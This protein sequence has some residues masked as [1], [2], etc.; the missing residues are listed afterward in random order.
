MSGV[1]SLA[2][3]GISITRRTEL[4]T[5]K[6]GHRA[7]TIRLFLHLGRPISEER[8]VTEGTEQGTECT[9]WAKGEGWLRI[10]Q[11]YTGAERGAAPQG[12]RQV[13]GHARTSRG[14]VTMES[15]PPN[16]V[17]IFT[18]RLCRSLELPPLSHRNSHAFPGRT[19]RR[20]PLARRSKQKQVFQ[21]REQEVQE[22]DEIKVFITPNSPLE[23]PAIIPL[24]PMNIGNLYFPSTN[25]SLS[26][27]LT[28]SSVLLLVHF[29]TKN[30]G[31]NSVPNAWQSLVEP[32]HDFVPNLVNEQIGGLSGNV[33]QKFSPRISVTF[34]SS[35]FRNPQVGSQRNGLHFS[36][37]S[38]PAGVPLP[39]APP[40]VLPE[41]IPHC[42]RASS[43]GIRLSANMMA[44]HSS[45]RI[46]SGSARTM[47]WGREQNEAS[48]IPPANRCAGTLSRKEWAGGS[49]GFTVPCGGYPIEPLVGGAGVPPMNNRILPTRTS[50]SKNKA[51]NHD[52]SCVLLSIMVPDKAEC[53]VLQLALLITHPFR[54]C[55]GLY[56]KGN[57]SEQESRVGL[58][59]DRITGNLRVSLLTLSSGNKMGPSVVPCRPKTLHQA[60][61]GQSFELRCSEQSLATLLPYI[62]LEQPAIIPLIPM[63]I[64]N[65]YFPSTNPSLSMPLTISSVLLLVHFVT[66]NGGGNSVP[67]AWQSLVEPIHDFVPNLV[68]EQIGGLSGNVKQ[69]FSPRISVTFTSSSFR[70][71]QVGSQRNGLHFSSFSSPAGV[72]LPLAPPSVLPE[73]IPHC[74]R[75]SSSGIRLSANMMA[76]HSSVRISSGSARTMPWGR[77]QNEASLIPPAN[78][79]AGTLSRK[80][81]A[82][83][84]TGFTVPCGGYP[85]EPLVG[86]AGVPPMNNRGGIAVKQPFYRKKWGSR[87]LPP[88]HI[89]V[90]EVLASAIL[91]M[92]KR[93]WDKLWGAE[94]GTPPPGGLLRTSNSKNKA[95]NHDGS[96]VLL[97]IMVPDK[98]E[99][100]VLQLALL[101]THPF[102]ACYGL[103]EKGNGS[104]QESRVGLKDDRITGNS[105]GAR[106]AN[107]PWA[108]LICG[109]DHWTESKKE[110]DF[111]MLLAN[112]LLNPLRSGRN[113][114]IRRPSTPSDSY[115][116]T[117]RHRTGRPILCEVLVDPEVRSNGTGGESRESHSLGSDTSPPP[118][119]GAA[120]TD[121]N[122][123]IPKLER[124]CAYHLVPCV[125]FLRMLGGDPGGWLCQRSRC[126]QLRKAELFGS[127]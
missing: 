104:E 4:G 108:Q 122:L 87:P 13:R 127:L 35:S 91:Y 32:I 33:K 51:T 82:G 79:C 21:F 47:P 23:Q 75:A 96:C 9:D 111:P 89:A 73:L 68:N 50:N 101:I 22:K 62:P 60:S 116:S 99:C 5:A 41:L 113:G 37:F 1:G 7:G 72:P 77:E 119:P 125:T 102:R 30:G 83:G 66:K 118:F 10:C 63:N 65:L 45:V 31:G 124:S 44:G 58:K 121:L 106:A 85:I 8:T 3:R 48:L 42:S 71:P 88:I 11:A 110:R 115:G 52:G 6:E 49:T 36:S 100:F 39:L 109:R 26:M 40:S 97:S 103:Y 57:G 76:G 59:D 70:N 93:S 107:M 12:A 105:E 120:G 18:K 123:S 53:F 20:F 43:S 95:T 15:I 64:G 98:A 24:I 78:R 27:P 29:V 56:E 55:Y 114:A 67:N 90:P 38:S 117:T 126:G 25:P 86:G 17:V 2:N 81:W 92:R 80:E 69:K 74:S 34:T 14:H 84:S 61:V 112:Y 46:S 94:P 54:A 28:I 16:S 19:N